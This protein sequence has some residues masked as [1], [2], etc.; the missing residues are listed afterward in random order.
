MHKL[1]NSDGFV[2]MYSFVIYFAISSSVGLVL[3]Q[4]YID[5][6]VIGLINAIH[7]IITAIASFVVIIR[8]TRKSSSILLTI[9]MVDLIVLPVLNI[10]LS[11]FSLN[12]LL[13]LLLSI[14]FF[15]ILKYKRII[16]VIIFGIIIGVL[17]S[18]ITSKFLQEDEIERYNI[19]S[20]C[21]YQSLAFILIKCVFCVFI[22]YHRHISFQIRTDSMSK[23]SNIIAYE[24]FV[25]LAVIETNLSLFTS[26]QWSKDTHDVVY[27]LL[28]SCRNT[29]EKIN[30]LM[31]NISIIGD[32]HSM[33]KSKVSV[34][35]VI[36]E[37]IKEY[38]RRDQVISL[39]IHNDIHFI[40]SKN[41]LKCVIL[42]I[43]N[44]SFQHGGNNIELDI[45]ISDNCLIIQD[46]GCGIKERSINDIFGYF[47]SSSK[48]NLGIGL[49]ISR[50]IVRSFGGEMKCISL[51]GSH[52]TFIITFPAI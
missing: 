28:N 39:G 52:T 13:N 2:I 47:T 4:K 31:N 15:W 5:I 20:A 6:Q 41:I 16:R 34:A 24:I 40:G 19:Y 51:E 26:M 29:R 3:S 49:A 21:E 43:I 27:Q 23:L 22:L 11:E 37:C 32:T 25:P 10:F 33:Q 42:N 48:E 36:K 45:I 8:K 9:F 38:E 14:V 44:N 46:N 30:F 12:S 18:F 1:F 35:K 7:I 50:D 17:A